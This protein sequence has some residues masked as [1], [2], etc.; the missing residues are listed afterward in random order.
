EGAMLVGDVASPFIPAG[1]V[2]H[3]VAAVVGEGRVLRI[4]DNI[5][6]HGR[7]VKTKA[8]GVVEYVKD[9]MFIFAKWFD[10]L[11]KFKR[12]IVKGTTHWSDD[13]L[14]GLE[15]IARAGGEGPEGKAV[16]EG[17]VELVKDEVSDEYAEKIAKNIKE[18]QDEGITGV[19]MS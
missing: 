8:G 11:C 17:F 19:L 9:D 4:A 7:I 6:E 14:D 1:F 12:C 3:G 16:A 2:G 10:D 5:G 13:A 18:L 15:S